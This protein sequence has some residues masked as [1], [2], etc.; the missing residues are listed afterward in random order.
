MATT[1]PKSLLLETSLIQ[2]N[3]GKVCVR[4]KCFDYRLLQSA[5]LAASEFA[6]NRAVLADGTEETNAAENYDD[7]DAGDDDE[8]EEDETVERSA[9]Y[10]GD[11][12]DKADLSDAAESGFVLFICS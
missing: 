10:E 6:F 8:D 1:I 12:E 3:S 11:E 4:V 2:S 7:N 5:K 9:D